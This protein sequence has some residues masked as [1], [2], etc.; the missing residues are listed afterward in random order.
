M[1]NIAE[2]TINHTSSQIDEVVEGLFFSL[3]S[4]SLLLV[5]NGCKR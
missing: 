5:K 4:N 2:E 3:V 1:S